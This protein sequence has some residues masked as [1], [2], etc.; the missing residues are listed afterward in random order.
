MLKRGSGTNTLLALLACS[1]CFGGCTASIA[2]KWV[3]HEVERVASP[4]GDFEAVVLTGDAGA[5]TRAAT[6]VRIVRT[7]VKTDT[8]KPDDNELVL[9]AS[10]VS[11]LVVRW[12]HPKVLDIQYGEASIDQ[13]RNHE[14]IQRA[15]NAWDVIEVRLCPT[16]P[17]ASLPSRG[18]SSPF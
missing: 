6:V 15:Q 5:T 14:E 7:G 10:D 17:D 2:G 1:C 13:F 12:K 8:G 11:N 3:F 4:G 9:W 16:N 18:Q